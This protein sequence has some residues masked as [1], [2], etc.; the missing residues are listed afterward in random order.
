MQEK[1]LW[2]SQV[3]GILFTCL[4]LNSNLGFLAVVRN[5]KQLKRNAID[6]L[7]IGPRPPSWELNS[8]QR[9]A[10]QATVRHC[11][12]LRD[13]IRAQALQLHKY[14]TMKFILDVHCCIVQQ[15]MSKIH[16]Q[17]LNKGD[18]IENSNTYHHRFYW[19]WTIKKYV[20]PSDTKVQNWMGV[21]K[22]VLC[23]SFFIEALVFIHLLW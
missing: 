23:P 15:C 6:N 5:H 12:K 17:K 4:R 3:T 21:N 20:V 10:W 18:W 9:W 1:Y 16:L 13:H 11:A 2:L 22:I 7:A 8:V 19:Y 14:P